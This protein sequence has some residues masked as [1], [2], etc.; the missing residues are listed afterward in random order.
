MIGKG[1]QGRPFRGSELS[2]KMKG[3]SEPDKMKAGG[4][5]PLGPGEV[6]NLLAQGTVSVIGWKEELHVFEG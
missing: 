3:W 4:R 1:N 6:R 5:V 2:A